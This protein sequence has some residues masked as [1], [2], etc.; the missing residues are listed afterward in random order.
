[1]AT[2]H[3]APG[4]P[5][6]A[7]PVARARRQPAPRPRRWGRPLTVG[8]ALVLVAALVPGAHADSGSDG[9][10]GGVPSAWDSAGDETFDQMV[11]AEAR[12]VPERAAD[13][14][15]NAGTPEPVLTEGSE[16]TSINDRPPGG[17]EPRGAVA[18]GVV[19]T[20]TQAT[21]GK[22]QRDQDTQDESRRT[23]AGCADGSCQ[24]E[25]PTDSPPTN[26]RPPRNILAAV[27]QDPGDDQ[28]G[29]EDEWD[30]D[31]EPEQLPEASELHEM[32]PALIDQ[33]IVSIWLQLRL[34][35]QLVQGIIDE[36]HDVDAR[37]EDLRQRLVERINWI[38]TVLQPALE[39]TAD[40]ES[41]A[42]MRAEAEAT[43]RRIDDELPVVSAMTGPLGEDAAQQS[44]FNRYLVSVDQEIDEAFEAEDRSELEAILQDIEGYIAMFRERQWHDHLVLAQGLRDKVQAAL[45][46]LGR[47]PGQPPTGEGLQN[48]MSM[49]NDATRELVNGNLEHTPPKI[50]TRIPPTPANPPQDSNLVSGKLG[51][52]PPK[53]DTRIPPTPAN[54][55]QEASAWTWTAVM[56]DWV[57]KGLAA[58]LAAMLVIGCKG[59]PCSNLL[60]PAFRGFPGAPGQG[61]PDH[62][63]G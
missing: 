50:D 43:L 39:G 40:A 41:V 4:R 6:P 17:E 20:D 9:G 59:A 53:I 13:L 3:P 51:H 45:G 28:D 23:A 16:G 48:P 47:S 11:Q 19:S 57:P 54:P 33:L 21:A 35:A 15:D 10:D 30:D 46:D 31:E 25:P 14:P 61:V 27:P 37:A 38:D 5:R 7:T 44:R 63:Q 8:L 2:A 62:L 34:T 26:I 36:P 56:T 24:Q 12:A 58:A 42:A 55:P 22:E 52:T 18:G 32:P 29:D 49:P 1:M 60:R